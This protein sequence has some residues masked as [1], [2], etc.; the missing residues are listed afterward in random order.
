M[1]AHLDSARENGIIERS[2]A[3]LHFAGHGRFMRR[4]RP[5]KL[6]RLLLATLVLVFVAAERGQFR[7]KR[8]KA[9]LRLRVANDA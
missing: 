1:S 2:V 8:P 6:D 3:F 7:T 5:T 4:H 9:V